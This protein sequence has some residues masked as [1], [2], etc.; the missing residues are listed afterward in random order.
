[1]QSVIELYRIYII[2]LIEQRSRM[3]ASA[4][5]VEAVDRKARGILILLDA[6]RLRLDRGF[7]NDGTLWP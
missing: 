5:A 3:R 6:K 2:I 4:P 7:A 1:L